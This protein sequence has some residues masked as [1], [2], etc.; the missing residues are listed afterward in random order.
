MAGNEK[1]SDMPAA[2]ALG[3]TEL[4]PVVAGGVNK[5]STPAAIALL[6]PQ[7]TVTSVGTGA[8][9]SGG[10]ITSSGTI[11]ISAT[12][13]AP[14][15]YGDATHV[16]Q[17][18]VN[19]Q[20]Q[21]TS[22][23]NIA[24]TGG[25]SVTSIATGTGLTGGPI[26]SSG[27]VSISATGVATG[28]YGDA[29]HVGAFTVNAGGQITS[30]SSVAIT[31]GGGSGSL[32]GVYEPKASVLPVTS[33]FTWDNQGTATTTDTATG[34]ILNAPAAATLNLRAL[35]QAAPAPPYT[36]YSRL[37]FEAGGVS[38]LGAGIALRNSISGKLLTW[39]IGW[40]GSTFA[41]NA[42][43]F[44]N[45]TTFSAS[46]GGALTPTPLQVQ[47]PWLAI[48]NDGTTVTFKWSI[49]GYVYNSF[50]TT[51]LLASFLIAGDQLALF[52][53][54]DNGPSLTHVGAF[55]TVQPS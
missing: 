12:G 35:W 11:S 49:N 55:Q 47:V 38:F 18:A 29:T 21:V 2:G 50:A 54:A 40:G 8:G 25:G 30:A 6:A 27:T 46:I 45:T 20:G 34:I 9:L 15:T 23:A 41:Y 31:G 3:G 1:I 7:G 16:A 32:V 26:T 19:A 13:V 10:P 24:I 4:V 17:V 33:N 44:T 37:I 51:E 36:L 48:S 28:T 39:S 43:R 53:R 14:A 42:Q 52:S 5:R 22:A